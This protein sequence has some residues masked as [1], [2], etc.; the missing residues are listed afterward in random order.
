VGIRY[1]GGGGAALPTT[2][3]SDPMINSG[4]VLAGPLYW[5]VFSVGNGAAGVDVDSQLNG[6]ATGLVF[7]SGSGVNNNSMRVSFFPASVDPAAVAAGSLSRG[8]FAQWTLVSR[9]A[10]IDCEV[11]L[12]LFSSPG[13]DNGYILQAQSES[14]NVGL[15]MGRGTVVVYGI[16]A[17]VMT[18][19]PGDVLRF[20][21]RWSP[22]SNN[23]RTFKNGVL[24][25]TDT[26]VNA[27]RPQGGQSGFGYLGVFTGVMVMKDFSCGLL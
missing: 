3:F 18:L 2:S 8:A 9:T 6:G 19:A 13:N 4:G 11:A 16:R 14:T 7:G 15:S 24:Q 25:S 22:A 5:N 26:D 17:N 23:L 10:G 21:A 27:G 12:C 1:D 20:E